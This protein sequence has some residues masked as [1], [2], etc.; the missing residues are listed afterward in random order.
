MNDESKMMENMSCALAR[1]P[2]SS[3]VF[4]CV[5]CRPGGPSTMGVFVARLLARCPSKHRRFAYKRSQE[6]RKGR[7]KLQKTVKKMT[8]KDIAFDVTAC[9]ERSYGFWTLKKIGINPRR[10]SAGCMSNQ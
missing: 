1:R 8:G 4:S 9:Y 6:P 5:R 2:A 3:L 10:P 7:P